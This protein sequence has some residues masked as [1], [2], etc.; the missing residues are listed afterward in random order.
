[1]WMEK[2][3]KIHG[4]KYW[5]YNKED[6]MVKYKNVI[7]YI[8]KDTYNINEFNAETNEIVFEYDS[9][10]RIRDFLNEFHMATLDKYINI[11]DWGEKSGRRIYHV[12]WNKWKDENESREHLEHIFS[13][14][15]E[16]R[17]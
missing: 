14:D 11:V 9:D 1:M 12:M 8:L 7:D 15:N 13:F 2:S 6:K 5:D 16:M 17:L 3:G 4:E 10:E